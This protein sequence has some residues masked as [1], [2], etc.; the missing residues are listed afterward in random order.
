MVP[1]SA[2]PNA[3]VA[4][5]PILDVRQR[6]CAYELLF[7]SSSE[8][9][10]PRVDGS[11]ASSR[12][13]HD[14]LHVFGLGALSARQRLYIN[15]TRDV[16]VKELVRALP[17]ERVTVEVL[18]TIE[19]DAEVVA[20]CAHLAQDGYEIALDDFIFRPG[21]EALIAVAD[22][23]KVDFTQTLGA[24]RGR[25]VERFGSP[26]VR[27]LA[28]KIE[29]R[30]E[31]EEAVHLGY[32]LFQGYF[33]A[34]PEIISARDIPPLKVNCLRLLT[35]VNEPELDFQAVE[36]IVRQEISI[37]VKLLKQLNSA[38]LGG[39]HRIQSIRHALELLG[40][41]QFRRWVSLLALTG[42]GGSEVPG[43]VVLASL[44]RARFCESVAAMTPLPLPTLP[45][46]LVGLLSMVDVLVAR[47][48]D[49]VLRSLAI[50]PEVEQALLR[51]EG[52]LA[53]LV[54]LAIAHERGDWAALTREALALG[55]DELATAEVHQA[56]LLWA[57]EVLAGT[58]V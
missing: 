22:V 51:D 39:H 25:V 7:R 9:C 56:S 23:I 38:A 52:R 6:T 50:D 2:P 36:A 41:V 13:L 49:E 55:V 19:P 58:T 42:A 33:F 27:M 1:F 47:P 10:F 3:F 48:I 34:R 16:L 28:E 40:E 54:P 57:H 24:E 46:F 12:I 14:S 43:E 45:S 26:R 44:T 29:T 35:V 20:A 15:V 30:A 17:P 8:N 4:R 53:H 31:F 32:E 37:A 18:E 5:Q 21:F 11:Y